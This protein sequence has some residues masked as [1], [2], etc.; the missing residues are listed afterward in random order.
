MEFSLSLYGM[1][2]EWNVLRMS[3]ES[4]IFGVILS[5]KCWFQKEILLFCQQNTG[6]SN[7]YGFLELCNSSSTGSRP[8]LKKGRF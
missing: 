3:I 4:V 8:H 5:T 6:L 7:D 2:L 1:S